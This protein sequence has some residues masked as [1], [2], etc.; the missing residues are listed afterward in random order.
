MNQSVREET[1]KTQ[2]INY[3]G[4][5]AV[6]R[7]SDLLSHWMQFLLLIRGWILRK[8]GWNWVE[9]D[10]FDIWVHD[11]HPK[12]RP[13]VFSMYWHRCKHRY[14]GAISLKLQVDISDGGP[15]VL[16]LWL[17]EP[18]NLCLLDISDRQI[19]WS[20]IHAPDSFCTWPPLLSSQVTNMHWEMGHK[21]FFFLALILS[22]K[23]SNWGV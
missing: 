11:T 20:V 2:E 1:I 16:Y 22:A 19:W 3:N 14:W 10:P 13:P 21:M 8:L 4:L 6:I 7:P 12:E 5:N 17:V 9:I 15:F 18:L 23:V